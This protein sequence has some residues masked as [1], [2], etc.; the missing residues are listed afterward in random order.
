MNTLLKDCRSGYGDAVLELCSEDKHVIGI[1][2]DL[3]ESVKLQAIKEQY[4]SQ[5]IDCGICEQHMVS[6]SG[7]M[8]LMGYIP[9]VSTFGAS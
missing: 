1:T 6:M 8:S 7:A 9:F 2:A 4:A 5:F 3:A